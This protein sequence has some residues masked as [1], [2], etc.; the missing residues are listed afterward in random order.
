MLSW[1]NLSRTSSG[2]WGDS[3]EQVV[4]VLVTQRQE[5]F[6]VNNQKLFIETQWCNNCIYNIFIE[7]NCHFCSVWETDNWGIWLVQFFCF[8]HFF[9]MWGF[10]WR[11]FSSWRDF[12]SYSLVF[13]TD[14]GSL[15]SSTYFYRFPDWITNH[16][17][18]RILQLLFYK[19]AN[20]MRWST[21][22]GRLSLPRIR[23]WLVIQSNHNIRAWL[24]K[25]PCPLLVGWVSLF[26]WTKTKSKDLIF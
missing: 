23:F 11:G 9:G 25:D 17:P 19:S 3:L 10:C 18:F 14:I 12:F 5:K 8:I 22:L 13:D 16:R 21:S 2:G 6:S 26:T 4:W 24:I 15:P 20:Q 7:R 1:H